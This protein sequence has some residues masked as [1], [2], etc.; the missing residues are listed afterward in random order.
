[1]ISVGSWTGRL[2]CA[3]LA[4][5]WI[6][7]I[8]SAKWLFILVALASANPSPVSSASP[9][10]ACNQYDPN[11]LCQGLISVFA[12]V[13]RVERDRQVAVFSAGSDHPL[14]GVRITLVLPD[15][16]RKQQSTG[17]SGMLSFQ[18]VSLMAEDD[19]LVEVEYPATYRGTSLVPCP[20]SSMRQRITRDMFGSMRSTR[21]VFCA[22]QGRA[23]IA[24]P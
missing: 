11:Q 17:E 21:L 3:N 18:N 1:M 13:D 8:Q 23:I 22:M 2:V 12:F 20:S 5:L 14:R 16:S 15:G 9:D 10:S 6:W 4:T 7:S 24:I 19:L